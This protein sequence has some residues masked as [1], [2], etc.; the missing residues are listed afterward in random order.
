ME[1]QT[2]RGKTV[3]KDHLTY[4]ATPF[5]DHPTYQATLFKDHPTYQAIF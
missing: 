5:K 4:Q 2:D 3:F 1:G